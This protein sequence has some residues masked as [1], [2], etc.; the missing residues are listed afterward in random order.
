MRNEDTEQPSPPDESAGSGR[1]SALRTPHSALPTEPATSFKWVIVAAVVV[2]G[3]GA[4]II[5]WSRFIS[6]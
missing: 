5:V 6:Q 4:S 2:W 1:D 3:L